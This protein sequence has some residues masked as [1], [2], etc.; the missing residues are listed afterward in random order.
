MK[1]FKE[2]IENKLT[3]FNGTDLIENEIRLLFK[4][5]YLTKNII[6]AEHLFKKLECI[7]FVLSK[8]IFKDHLK[9]SAFAKEFIYDFDRIDDFNVKE[10]QYQKIKKTIEL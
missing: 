10:N 7:Q 9:V 4:E 6:E 1:E 8:A 5:I 2:F 3:L